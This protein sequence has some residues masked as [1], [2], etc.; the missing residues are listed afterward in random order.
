MLV[1]GFKFFLIG[2]LCLD[3]KVTVSFYFLLGHFLQD[4]FR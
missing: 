3:K 4:V 1:K 2:L